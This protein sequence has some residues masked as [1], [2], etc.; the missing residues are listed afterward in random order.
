[1]HSPVELGRL[2]SGPEAARTDVHPLQLSV[3]EDP[4]TLNVG[5]EDTVGLGGA[6][7][8][9]T[10]V[11]V[12]DVAAEHLALAAEVTL[13]HAPGTPSVC[14]QALSP[15]RPVE[16]SIPTRRG[17]VGPG[18]DWRP[19]SCRLPIRDWRR[20]CPMLDSGT[21]VRGITTMLGFAHR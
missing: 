15:R 5:I 1:M 3:H 10:A 13:S 6:K 17:A 11:V 19:E 20:S 4:S 2:L 8:P 7:L 14:W 16:S 9:L 12:P 18:H 21:C